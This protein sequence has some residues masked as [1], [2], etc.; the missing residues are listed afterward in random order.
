M[1]CRCLISAALPN[2]CFWLYSGPGVAARR[3]LTRS[4]MSTAAASV[5]VDG[6]GAGDMQGRSED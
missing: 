2:F 5:V 1:A 6:Y 4:P 3:A